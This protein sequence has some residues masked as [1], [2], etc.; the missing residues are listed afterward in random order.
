MNRRRFFWL[1]AAAFVIGV[2]AVGAYVYA[3]RDSDFHVIGKKTRGV[4]MN[5]ALLEM[6]I[7]TSDFRDCK[8]VRDALNQLRAKLH[9]GERGRVLDKGADEDWWWFERRRIDVDHAAFAEAGITQIGDRPIQ[10]PPD[11]GTMT[12]KQLLRTIFRRTDVAEVH[13]IVRWNII[14]AS[15]AKAADEER[16]RYLDSV[17]AY[18]RIRDWWKE[19]NGEVEPDPPMMSIF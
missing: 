5:L 1:G 19:I 11:S 12:V 4:R 16:A 2:I 3:T 7:D 18:D 8:T 14:E 15:T 9:E 6:K 10:F 13:Y 17:S